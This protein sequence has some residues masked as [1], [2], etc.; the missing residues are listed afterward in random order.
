MG[1]YWDV[2]C[3]VHRWQH[4]DLWEQW[5][6]LNIVTLG[7]APGDGFPLRGGEAKPN[8]DIARSCLKRVKIGDHVV[9][10]TD[11]PG[12]DLGFLQSFAQIRQIECRHAYSKVSRTAAR[13]RRALG[14]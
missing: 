14:M 5:L 11:V 7:W 9:A 2:F 13:M 1:E 12:D 3:G 10:D 6:D 4:I 8:W